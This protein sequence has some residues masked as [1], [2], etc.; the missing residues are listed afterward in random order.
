MINIHHTQDYWADGSGTTGRI[1]GQK[2]HLTSGYFLSNKALGRPVEALTYA[3]RAKIHR[4]FYMYIGTSY[5]Y[6]TCSAVVQ[7]T[8]ASIRRTGESGHIEKLPFLI[9]SPCL[10]VPLYSEG[11]K[12]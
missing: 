5:R 6:D 12:T 3:E 8:Y 2:L 9:I 7:S 4:K 1:A 11:A 10:S